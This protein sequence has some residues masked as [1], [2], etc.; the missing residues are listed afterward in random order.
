MEGDEAFREVVTNLPGEA[1]GVGEAERLI[2]VPFVTDHDGN[3]VETAVAQR[4]R[5]VVG[6]LDVVLVHNERDLHHGVTVTLPPDEIG[7]K[8][9]TALIA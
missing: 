5:A 7:K 4:L 6:T 2:V 8:R 9:V 1:Q 3:R